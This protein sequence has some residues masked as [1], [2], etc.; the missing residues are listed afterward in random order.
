MQNRVEWLQQKLKQHELIILDGATGSEVS[1][2]GVSTTMPLWSA[3]AL[4]TAPD[5]VRAIHA[6]YITAGADIITTNTFRTNPRV[7]EASGCGISSKD[8]TLR[9]CDLAQAAREAIKMPHVLVAGCIAPIEDCY[10]PEQ[11]PPDSELKS[12]HHEFAGYL[13]EGGVDFI[14]IET[15]N[16]IREAQAALTAAAATG[17]PYSI[18]F[19]CDAADNLLS[20]EPLTAALEMLSAFNPLFVCINCRPPDQLGSAFTTLVQNSAFPTGIY[21][22]GAGC[23]EACSGWEFSNPGTAAENYLNYAREWR[24][25]GASIIGGCCGTSPEY[26]ALLNKLRYAVA[27]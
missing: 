1:R 26:I 14:F 2:R 5:I 23:P 15:M 11:V 19:I 8:A 22:N 10:E 4:W 20:G 7:M 25:K 3:T 16:C 6:D 21:A 17:L 24:L 9:A 18:S 12:E 27:A 13:A